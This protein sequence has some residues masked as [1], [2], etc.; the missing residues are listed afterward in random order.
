MPVISLAVSIFRKRRE[1]SGFI[2]HGSAELF[3]DP[4]VSIQ[5]HSDETGSDE[6]RG[7]SGNGKTAHPVALL[8]VVER[9]IRASDQRSK[10]AQALRPEQPVPLGRGV[11]DNI[12]R[13]RFDLLDQVSVHV[14]DFRQLFGERLLRVAVD[15]NG[16]HMVAV[17]VFQKIRDLT[18]HPQGLRRVR[19]AHHDQEFGVI[20][21]CADVLRQVVGDR[22]LVL[23]AKD[24]A[25][26]LAAVSAQ[27][28]GDHIAL[29]PPVQFFCDRKIQRFVTVADKSY[30]IS[31]GCLMILRFHSNLSVSVSHAHF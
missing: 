9:V 20:E 23:V 15:Q 22:K 2:D 19:T 29:D 3:F 10:Y 12:G 26:F 14:P 21:G 31:F 18:L 5:E 25:K 27:L 30:V 1:R 11:R 24:E 8:A 17:V 28:F 7:C 13:E 16:Q 4:G 6:Q